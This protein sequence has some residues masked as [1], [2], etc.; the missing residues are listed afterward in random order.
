MSISTPGGP[1]RRPTVVSTGKKP[2]AGRPA[3]GDKP[4]AKAGA[5]KAGG[6]KGTPRP[7]AGGKGRKP[8]TPVKVSQGRSW[9]PIALFVAVGVLAVGII[10]VGAWAVYQ[11]AQPWQ[12]R[13]DAING[14]VN[15]RDKDPESLKY[16]KHQSGPLK[17]KYS[18][19][20]GGVHNDAWQNCMGDVYDAPIANEHAVHSLEHGAVWI[21]YR[22]DLPQDQVEK[23]AGKVR[24]T[25]K[26]LM[27]PYEGLDK[28]ISL[29]AWGYQLKVDNAD[30]ER[31]D[32]FIK[33]L[34]VNASVEGP[35]ALC[36]QGVTATGT[37]PRDLGAQMPTQ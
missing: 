6:G 7:G 37:T 29:Q 22:P 17:Y 36:N 20:V 16:E 11:G 28:A 9:G 8:V 34:R 35:T 23:L 24:G 14:I 26:M 27:S 18:P 12:K 2:A 13:A 5:G 19:P 33:D 10:G 32:E 30:D 15:Y 1:E 3:A 31:I 25:E 4:A 21:T